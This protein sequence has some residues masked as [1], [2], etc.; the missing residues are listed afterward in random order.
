MYWKK[1]MDTCVSFKSHLFEPFLSEEGQVNPHVY[2]A[3]LAWW[4]SRELASEGIETTYPNSEDWGWFIEFLIDD[5]EYW[6]CCGNVDDSKSNWRVYLD[7]KPK[8]MFNRN[9]APVE[10]AMPLLLALKTVLSRNVEISNIV[11]SSE[12]A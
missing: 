11:W 6:L 7:C 10:K 1:Y 5:N 8:S 3:E 9:K 4:L 12:I 2:G